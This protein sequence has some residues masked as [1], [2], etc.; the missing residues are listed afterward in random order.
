MGSGARTDFGAARTEALGVLT[1]KGESMQAWKDVANCRATAADNATNANEALYEML[2][3][4]QEEIR[5]LKIAM[6]AGLSR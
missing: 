5:N 2:A 3:E 6:A 4:Q 1:T